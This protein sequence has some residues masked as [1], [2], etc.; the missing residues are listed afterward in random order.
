VA[1]LDRWQRPLGH[2]RISVTDRCNLRCAYCMPEDEYVWLPRPDLLT[3]EE[4]TRVT[5]VFVSLGLAHV[6]LTGG[7]PL[8]RR[9]LPT[10]V[11]HLARLEGLTDLAMT[12][13]GVLLADNAGA[14]RQ[15]GLRRMTVSLDTLDPRRFVTLT[16]RDELTRV[17]AG[18]DAATRTFGTV[19][20]DTVLMRG[21][22]DDELEALVDFADTTGAEIRFIEYMDV[23][24]A[25]RWAPTTVVSQAEIL[26]RLETKYGAVEPL[27]ADGPAPAGRFRLP[28]GQVIGII[29][30]T[31]QPFCA[32]C[33]RIRLTAD[34]HL[35]FC[36]Y[37]TRGL[38]LRTPLRAGASD[39]DLASLITDAWQA[40]AD[41]GAA[42]RL[43]TPDRT[44]FIPAASLRSQ[45]HLE[46]HTRGG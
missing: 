16:R 10:L 45:P 1:V 20:F 7:E 44:A 25:T 42:E 14:L 22:N 3:F 43:A 13:N 30:S 6:R 12:S 24:G 32:T 27:P 5:R 29:A 40:R 46:M 41:R 21:V 23:P 9:D 38:D 31:T 35:F 4:I 28:H 26:G 11:A 34:G 18:I 37:A 17:L 19:K 2:L 36:L 33:D 15:A 8:L 39:L